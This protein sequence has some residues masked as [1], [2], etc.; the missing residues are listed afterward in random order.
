MSPAFKESGWLLTSSLGLNYQ[1]KF[2]SSNVYS[3]INNEFIRLIYRT[4]VG[5]TGRGLVTLKQ[6]HCTVFTQQGY[7]LPHGCT[8]RG[9]FP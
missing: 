2:V 6:L 5:A 3:E 7:W 9:P 8:D 1:L 4:W